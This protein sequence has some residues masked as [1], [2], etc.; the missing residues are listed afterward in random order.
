MPGWSVSIIKSQNYQKEFNSLRHIKEVNPCVKD[1]HTETEEEPI[2]VNRITLSK[3]EFE[4]L[5]NEP[6][7]V[8]CKSKW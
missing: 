5:K 2:T 3:S 8:F 6:R 1:L 4:T 7:I